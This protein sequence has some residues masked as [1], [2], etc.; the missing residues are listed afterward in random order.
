[1]EGVVRFLD[2]ALAP[3]ARKAGLSV[4]APTFEEVFESQLP[5]EVRERLREFSRGARKALPLTR[6]ET[7]LWHE[8]VIL[9]YRL[10]ALLD[11]D[12][13]AGWLVADG[14]PR[15]AGAELAS[16]FHEH[17]LL[18]ARYEEEVSVA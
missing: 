2:D 4:L 16:R 5:F 7:G 17:A 3:A 8:F 9:A 12:P 6:E 14:W 15:D 10:N 18:L 1:W 11:P 13:F